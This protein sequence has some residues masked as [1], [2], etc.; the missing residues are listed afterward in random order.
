M[1]SGVRRARIRALTLE[2]VQD[3]NKALRRLARKDNRNEAIRVVGRAD[4]V[5]LPVKLRQGEFR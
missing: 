2:G 3:A 5:Q 1:S 4:S